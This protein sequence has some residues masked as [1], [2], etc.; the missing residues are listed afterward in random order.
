MSNIKNINSVSFK[1]GYLTGTVET[2]LSVLVNQVLLS[3]GIPIIT[4]CCNKTNILDGQT[5]VY[6]FANK[7]WIP[8]F[9]G[10][11]GATNLGYTASALNGIITNTN[12]TIATLPLV[13]ATNAGLATPAMFNAL[14]GSTPSS[15][16]IGMPVTFA[17]MRTKMEITSMKVLGVPSIVGSTVTLITKFWTKNPN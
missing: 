8:T 11:G 2:N 5:L 3:N 7:K 17:E 6:S 9:G 15:A 16:Q 10:A 4:G 1:P 13:D 12:G 14:S